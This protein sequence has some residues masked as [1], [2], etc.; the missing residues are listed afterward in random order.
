[1]LNLGPFN[2][3]E[4]SGE[5]QCGICGIV[6]FYKSIIKTKKYGAYTCDS[7]RK[8]LSK[9]IENKNTIN[10]CNNER[11]NIVDGLFFI[12][13]FLFYIL[14]FRYRSVSYSNWV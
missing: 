4:N 13:V 2:I 8:F 5:V 3:N 1:M 9:S 11:G 12:K 10:R 6:R 14:L 7:C